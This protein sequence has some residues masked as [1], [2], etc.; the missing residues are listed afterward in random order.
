MHCLYS[1]IVDAKKMVV[2]VTSFLVHWNRHKATES[3]FSS[4]QN[5]G[6][7]EYRDLLKL[8]GD[9]YKLDQT[10]KAVHALLIYIYSDIHM[11]KLASEHLL[12]TVGF[13]HPGSHSMVK[14]IM[15]YTDS[16]KQI[17]LLM[18]EDLFFPRTIK[19]GTQVRYMDFY[20]KVNTAPRYFSWIL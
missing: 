17:Y 3:Y 12:P 5:L 6:F 2:S 10:F 11:T 15:F 7:R 20:I 16:I 4:Q 19:T 14:K 18:I 9:L 1:N 13:E 8:I